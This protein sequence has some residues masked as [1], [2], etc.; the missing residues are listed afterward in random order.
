MVKNAQK[1]TYFCDIFDIQ[2]KYV[3][4]FHDINLKVKIFVSNLKHSS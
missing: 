3:V 2:S 4:L 1:V